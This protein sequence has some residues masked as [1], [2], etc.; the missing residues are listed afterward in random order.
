MPA[1][2]ARA[3]VHR[4]LVL[5]QQRQRFA[6]GAVALRR[7][8]GRGESTEVLV[9]QRL[10]RAQPRLLAR[11]VG[12]EPPDLFQLR[13]PAAARLLIRRQERIRCP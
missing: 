1:S 11:V 13:L 6:E 9:D 4:P 10:E 12:R 7:G 2:S 3:P 5:R 8:A